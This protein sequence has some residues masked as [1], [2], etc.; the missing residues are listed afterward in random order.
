VIRKR[1]PGRVNFGPR[2]LVRVWL[3]LEE[4]ALCLSCEA[5]Y[6]LTERACPACGHREAA[7][8]SKWLQERRT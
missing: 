3:P 2:V 1:P 8:L 5:V 6:Q 4:A 7:L